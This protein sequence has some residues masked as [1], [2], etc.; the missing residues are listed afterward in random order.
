MPTTTHALP[1]GGAIGLLLA[2]LLTG[3]GGQAFAVDAVTSASQRAIPAGRQAVSIWIVGRGFVAGAQVQ[4]SGDGI[5]SNTPAQVVPEA[6]RVDGGRGDGITYTFD[7]DFNAAVGPRDITITNPDGSSATGSGIFE[8][9]P[10]EDP[11]PDPDAGV[12]DPDPNPDPDPD[13]DPGADAGAPDP[14]PPQQGGVVDVVTRASPRFG[15]QGAQINIWIVGRDFA[16]GAQIEFS[17]PG[18]GPATVNDEALDFE[19]VRRAESEGGEYDGITYYMR[20]G[21][22]VPEGPVDIQVTNPDGSTAV[23]KS[24]FQVVAPGTLP[25]PQPGDGDVDEITGAS[26]R[27]IRAGRHVSMWIWGRGFEPE[28]NLEYSNPK[29]T[30]YAPPQVV[31]R[32]TTHPGYSGIRS[33]IIVEPDAPS[34]PVQLRVTNPNGTQ[35]LGEGLLEVLGGSGSGGGAVNPGG[36]SGGAEV[37][38][39]CPD[40]VTVIE[41]V[42]QVVPVEAEAGETFNMAIVG[43]GFACGASIVIT[44]G[45]LM[46]LDQPRLVASDPNDPYNRT[47]FWQVQVLDD[48]KPGSRDVTVVNPNGTSKTLTDAFIVTAAGDEA[49]KGGVKCSTSSGSAGSQLWLWLLGLGLLGVRRRQ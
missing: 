42:S 29:I 2:L 4:I 13:P 20:I 44:G 7:I 1:R 19:L 39:P 21:A 28:A 3:W 37:G 45:G 41:S 31:R 22:E 35:A 9:L 49:S 6:S 10:P 27:A 14:V 16:P 38:G 15:E 34:G 40:N 32:S 25:P 46:A 36:G 48:A 30:S 18:I 47:L 24:I 33:F 17:Q 23:G 8:I 43:R 5:T 26:P 11:P 12:P